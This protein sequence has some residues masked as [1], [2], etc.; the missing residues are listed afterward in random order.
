MKYKKSHCA[1]TKFMLCITL[2]DIAILK[3]KLKKRL[4]PLKKNKTNDR[5]ECKPTQRQRK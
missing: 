3:G 5:E 1:A 4:Q 2:Y